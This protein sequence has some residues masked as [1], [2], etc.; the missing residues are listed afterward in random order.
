[1]DAF[2]LL[3]G[4]GL[5]AL[6]CLVAIVRGSIPER[7]TKAHPSSTTCYGTDAEVDYQTQLLADL[8]DTA[9]RNRKEAWNV[10]R[11]RWR[12]RS[13]YPSCSRSRTDCCR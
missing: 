7:G 6:V 2:L 4:A 1:M 5:G 13:A 9:K 11:E 12:L 3:A 10:A 8:A